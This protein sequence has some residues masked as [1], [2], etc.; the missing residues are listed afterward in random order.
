M[1]VSATAAEMLPAVSR[2]ASYCTCRRPAMTS[3]EKA[4]R[5]LKRFRRREMSATSSWQSIPST[6]K[7]DSAWT[8]QTAQAAKKTE[9]MR[10]GRLGGSEQRRQVADAELG[11]RQRAQHADARRV[12]E[13]LEC[14]GEALD[15]H[16]IRHRSANLRDASGVSVEDVAGV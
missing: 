13:R 2:A 16:R 5:P 11:T 10:D 8:S 7:V 9:L 12:A 4:S 15:R 6:R 1:P 3:A 14:L